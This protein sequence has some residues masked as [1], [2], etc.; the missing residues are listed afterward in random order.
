MR[1]RA[2]LVGCIGLAVIAVW[3]IASASGLGDAERIRGLVEDAGSLAPIVFVLLTTALFWAFLLVPPVWASVAIWPLPVAFAL[4]FTACMLGSL[5]MYLV[6]RRL[7][8]DWAERRVPAAIRR[9]QARLEARPLTTIVLLRIVLWAN[10]FADLLIALS[11]IP[12]RTYL[13]GTAIGLVPPTAGHLLLA[14]G[15]L[16][17]A[18]TLPL[19]AIALVVAAIAAAFVV[20]R[21]MNRHRRAA[22]AIEPLV[23]DAP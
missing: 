17:A 6:A 4:S 21:R 10:P 9:H 23:E 2:P 14:A 5:I 20:Y 18:K 12:L 3:W 22:A 11:R 13:V 7:G 8:P 19:W 16:Q 1:S 15:G